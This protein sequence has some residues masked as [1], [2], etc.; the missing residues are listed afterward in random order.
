MFVELEPGRH[1]AK[2]MQALDGPDQRKRAKCAQ[3][4]KLGQDER[5]QEGSDNDHVRQAGRA[6]ECLPWR[7]RDGDPHDDFGADID[8]DDD[9]E[10]VP[11]P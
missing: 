6:Q 9:E 2:V 11:R 4:R 10:D 8:C 1:L 7:T 3:N 5:R